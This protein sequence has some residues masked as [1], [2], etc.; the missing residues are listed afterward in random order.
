MGK[1]FRVGLITGAVLAGVALIWVATRP[2][3]GPRA[4]VP[5]PAQFTS[6][7][8]QTPTPP[9]PWE[10]ADADEADRQQSSR[11]ETSRPEDL[12]QQ[13]QSSVSQTPA[14]AGAAPASSDPTLGAGRA[15]PPTTG[16][17]LPDLT[18]HETSE[19]IKT[20]RFHIVRKG[21]SLSSIAAQYL[22]SSDQWRKI[23]TAN[24]KIIKDPNK[25]APGTKLII[26]D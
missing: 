12:L 23:V 8:E 24:Q 21:E 5:Q 25:I 18:I 3:L 17:P 14:P 26:P 2:S 13:F 7:A 6:K 15:T 19:P 4:R 16:D 11:R 20:T 10:S 1:D 9:L 22:G